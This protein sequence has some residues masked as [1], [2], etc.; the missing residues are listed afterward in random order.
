MQCTLVA[1]RQCAH[2]PMHVQGAAAA[3]ADD[4][5]DIEGGTAVDA[6]T[7]KDSTDANAADHITSEATEKAAVSNV[8]FKQ[9]PKPSSPLLKAEKAAGPEA[10][11]KMEQTGTAA[12]AKA[13]PVT[14]AE[15]TAAP[16]TA[17]SDAVALDT[18][19]ED[20]T[21]ADT[22]GIPSDIKP[23][24][25]D[26]TQQS[27]ADASEEEEEQPVGKRRGIKRKQTAAGSKDT[28]QQQLQQ[29]GSVGKS[30][31]S[32]S[33]PSTGEEEEQQTGRGRGGRGRGRG[34][35]GSRGRGR[36]RGQKAKGKA[37]SPSP[38]SSSNAEQ[39]QA[40]FADALDSPSKS[41]QSPRHSAEAPAV[42]AQLAQDKAKAPEMGSAR[43]KAASKDDQPLP[44]RAKKAQAPPAADRNQVTT[45]C[46]LGKLPVQAAAGF[47]LSAMQKQ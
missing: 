10:T 9:Q 31:K 30:S 47:Q 33:A 12:S 43:R 27:N 16:A 13:A 26:V 20:T 39:D 46:S 32:K 7:L 38:E 25:A 14:A 6:Q 21:A 3:L 11:D 17:A 28:Q 19:A 34:G 5:L 29:Q 22:A 4:D 24:Q 18:A 37:R 40:D 8:A 42:A 23:E 2:S 45:L 36:G 35:R 41:A 15:D 44:K 1:L